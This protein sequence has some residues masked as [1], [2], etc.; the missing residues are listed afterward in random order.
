MENKSL[1]LKYFLLFFHYFIDHSRHLRVTFI[2]RVGGHL[3]V[4]FIGRIGGHL[5]VT[6]IGRM[7]GHLRVT[8][9]GRV[10]GLLTF[11]LYKC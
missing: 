7:G 3:R 9:I 4:T 5:R 6:F 8:F 1:V 10:G 2:G 11:A